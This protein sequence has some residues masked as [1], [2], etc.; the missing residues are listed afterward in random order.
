[1]SLPRVPLA[2][3]LTR[4][5]CSAPFSAMKNIRY[6]ITASI[7]TALTLASCTAAAATPAAPAA[8]RA[9]G[10]TRRIRPMRRKQAAPM[11]YRI[12]RVS[13]ILRAISRGGAS[14]D[15]WL[16][17]VPLITLWEAPSANADRNRR[18]TEGSDPR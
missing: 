18:E 4:S 13:H 7:A 14:A 11:E 10:L 12:L 16:S 15:A 2:R 5:L 17:H 8:G 6:A 1:M 9:A 3:L